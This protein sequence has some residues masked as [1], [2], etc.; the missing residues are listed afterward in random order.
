MSF[1]HLSLHILFILIATTHSI[2]GM[3]NVI[4]QNITVDAGANL[5]ANIS[6]LTNA[7]N[8]LVLAVKDSGD[9][10]NQNITDTAHKLIIALNNL[11]H[12][13]ERSAQTLSN[14]AR[15]VCNDAGVHVADIAG[16]LSNDMRNI[17]TTL[18][19]D[20]KEATKE[21]VP[22]LNSIARNGIQTHHSFGPNPQFMKSFFI[23]TAGLAL[24]TVSLALLYKELTKETVISSQEDQNKEKSWKDTFKQIL[25]N[26]YLIGTSGLLSGLLLIN[27]CANPIA[28]AA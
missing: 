11:I 9:L 26:R 15:K 5:S 28:P 22:A 8:K 20:I 19:A 6:E 13:T 2:A 4:P 7:G 24:V 14:D 23:G 18:S 16:A 17:A 1:K 3:L 12:A 21:F 25:S 10:V 27:R